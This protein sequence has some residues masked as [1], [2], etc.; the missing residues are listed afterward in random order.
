MEIKSE[1][2][3]SNKSTQEFWL[4]HIKEWERSKLSQGASAVKSCFNKL[5]AAFAL[6]LTFVVNLKRFFILA[7]IPVFF[8]RRATRL[9]EHV[10]P[11][12]NMRCLLLLI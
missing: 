9:R 3:N 1:L 4:D 10:S 8:I 2:V 12:K 7:S 5:G 6:G 11:C